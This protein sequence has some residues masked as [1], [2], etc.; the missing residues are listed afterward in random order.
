MAH[1]PLEL[2][3][4]GIR[5]FSEKMT[6]VCLLGE[7]GENLQKQ[8]K[9]NTSPRSPLFSSELSVDWNEQNSEKLNLNNTEMLRER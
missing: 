5:G 7:L 4:C 3:S 9:P 6:K 1:Q 2:A 8:F